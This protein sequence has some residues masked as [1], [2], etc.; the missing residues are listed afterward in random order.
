MEGTTP[1]WG[2]GVSHSRSDADADAD[3]DAEADEDRE[4]REGD[5]MGEDG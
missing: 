2:G 1:P 4:A 3:A 5:D